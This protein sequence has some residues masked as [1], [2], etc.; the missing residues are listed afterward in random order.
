MARSPFPGSLLFLSAPQVTL[1]LGG[2][3]GPC[4]PM[5][6][7]ALGR[8]TFGAAG[9]ACP[10]PRPLTCTSSSASTPDPWPLPDREGDEA[11]LLSPVL[12]DWA[13]WS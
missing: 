1:S 7:L 3:P 5:P 10:G 8:L 6:A 11:S 9:P 12:W 2:L 13:G 4:Q